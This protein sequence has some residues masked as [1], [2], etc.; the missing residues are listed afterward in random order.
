M[1]RSSSYKM[2]NRNSYL[3]K[4]QGRRPLGWQ[5][6]IP[7]VTRTPAFASERAAEQVSHMT[8]RKSVRFF[9]GSTYDVPDEIA[10]AV[11]SD[12]SCAPH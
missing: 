9:D 6:F 11:H 10:V 2:A 8:L 4:P 5:P 3:I 7:D 12:P 1:C